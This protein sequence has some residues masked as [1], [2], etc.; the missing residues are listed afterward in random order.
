MWKGSI[1]PF[2]AKDFTLLVL[3]PSKKFRREFELTRIVHIDNFAPNSKKMTD[4][5]LVT[6][7]T[8]PEVI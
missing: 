1:N 7:F 4:F 2:A 6:L 8:S 3:L 5:C